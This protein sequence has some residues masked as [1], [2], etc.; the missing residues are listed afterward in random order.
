MAGKHKGLQ[1][2]C[3][4]PTC[5][6]LFV[7][8]PDLHEYILPCFLR[9]YNALSQQLWSW[10]DETERG[11]ARLHL[12]QSRHV[13]L[14][15]FGMLWYSSSAS[16]HFESTCASNSRMVTC[17]WACSP[18]LLQPYYHCVFGK[19]SA[20]SRPRRFGCPSPRRVQAA[21]GRGKTN[22]T[23]IQGRNNGP[24]HRSCF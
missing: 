6:W 22:T 16:H 23:V 2:K 7:Q 5:S 24:P 3:S 20:G 4:D 18:L 15:H 17:I 10:S 21:R 9:I 14:P 12:V 19:G 13:P 8:S 11:A 1:T